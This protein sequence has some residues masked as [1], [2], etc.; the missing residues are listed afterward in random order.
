MRALGVFDSYE[1]AAEKLVQIKRRQEPVSENTTRYTAFYDVYKGLYPATKDC[2][3]QL[4]DIK[5][6]FK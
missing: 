4:S 6:S 1:E 3:A 5:R 2:M